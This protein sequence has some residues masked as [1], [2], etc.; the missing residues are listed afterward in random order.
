MFG[1]TAFELYR[2]VAICQGTNLPPYNVSAACFRDSSAY[3]EMSSSSGYQNCRTST[4]IEYLKKSKSIAGL[5]KKSSGAVL[6]S[7]S[8]R[9]PTFFVC[10]IDINHFFES[11]QVIIAS[12]PQVTL[13][14]SIFDLI[15][16][17]RDVAEKD[18]SHQSPSEEASSSGPNWNEDFT[19]DATAIV[20]HHSSILRNKRLLLAYQYVSNITIA[21]TCLAVSFC[22]G[23]CLTL[24]I[25]VFLRGF[26]MDCHL[27][28]PWCSL[29]RMDRIRSLRWQQRTL[30]EN[31]K[32]NLSPAEQQVTLT[33]PQILKRWWCIKI[34]K[35]SYATTCPYML[36]WLNGKRGNL[37]IAWCTGG[38]RIEYGRQA[39][40]I[41]SEWVSGF[42]GLW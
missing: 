15:L 8:Y 7:P 40:E 34:L 42:Q 22:M 17:C 19:E 36:A 12:G 33:I 29:A 9:Q 2:D 18:A 13:T 39:F 16:I 30:P 5:S 11:L 4:Y 27:Q 21:T 6:A 10:F 26:D 1:R 25:L 37:R 41:D 35:V 28:F 32:E 24:Q 14:Q 31:I 20:I 23:D 3:D 38:N